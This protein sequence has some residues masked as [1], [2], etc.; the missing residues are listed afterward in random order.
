MLVLNSLFESKLNLLLKASDDR[1][2]MRMSNFKLMKFVSLL[3]IIAL[4]L[5]K[6][7]TRDDLVKVHNIKII[8]F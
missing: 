8:R 5:M 6:R 2:I 7:F 1:F 4:F 3:K